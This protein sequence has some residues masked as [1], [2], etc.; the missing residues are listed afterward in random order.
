MLDEVSYD[1]EHSG[2]YARLRDL[3]NMAGEST[4][5]MDKICEYIYWANQSNL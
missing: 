5:H 4:H 3:A 1:E 2:F